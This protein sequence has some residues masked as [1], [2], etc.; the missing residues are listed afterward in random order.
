MGDS[1]GDFSTGSLGGFFG[2]EVSKRFDGG[3][4]DGDVFA[5]SAAESVFF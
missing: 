4:G 2:K 1:G 5:G 3:D